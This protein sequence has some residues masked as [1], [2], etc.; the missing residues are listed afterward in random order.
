MSYEPLMLSDTAMVLLG[1][2]VEIEEYV[3]AI[4]TALYQQVGP[5]SRERTLAE[6][7]WSQTHNYPRSSL[8]AMQRQLR[9]EIWYLW[10]FPDI[11]VVRH[12]S[13]HLVLPQNIISYIPDAWRPARAPH[14]PE[15]FFSLISLSHDKQDGYLIPQIVREYKMALAAHAQTKTTP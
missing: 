12:L 10:M 8:M 14:R 11:P 7:A 6:N 1:Q 13:W 15:P 2:Y 3:L 4:E 5:P 9:E